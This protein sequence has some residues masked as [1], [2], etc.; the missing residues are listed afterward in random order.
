MSF[1]DGV[2]TKAIDNKTDEKNDA[3]STRKSFLLKSFP[4]SPPLIKKPIKKKVNTIKLTN[5]NNPNNVLIP[6]SLVNQ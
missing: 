5:N 4:T 6:S 2:N 3:F 1:S